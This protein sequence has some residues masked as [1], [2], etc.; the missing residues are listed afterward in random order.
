MITFLTEEQIKELN[1]E[2]NLARQEALRDELNEQIQNKLSGINNK[3][4]QREI[5]EAILQQEDEKEI[6]EQFEEYADLVDKMSSLYANKI[7]AYYGSEE[8]AQEIFSQFNKI[9]DEWWNLKKE[10]EIF[11]AQIQQV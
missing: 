1:F 3:G 11:K 9:L 8:S 5:D 2:E 10:T 6:E 7:I 4:L